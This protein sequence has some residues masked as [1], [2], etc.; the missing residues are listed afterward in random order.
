MNK[1]IQIHM[2]DIIIPEDF[3][4]TKPSKKKM[5]QCR[6]F[7]CKNGYIDKDII[8][9]EYNILRDGY[10]RYLVLLENNVDMVEVSTLA[11][12]RNISTTYVYGKHYAL[13]KEY[14]WRLTKRTKNKEALAVG[15]IARV[16][17][18][19]KLCTVEITKIEVLDRPPVNTRV[20]KVYE[21]L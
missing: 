4:K 10:I 5:V 1:R 19:G 15:K 11:T 14:V 8:V 6:E 12:Y 7:D 21:V 18:N 2:S 3:K 16:N 20:K 17:A 9:N 13:G